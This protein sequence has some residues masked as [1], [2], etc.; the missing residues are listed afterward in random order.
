M[1][2]VS[3]AVERPR[4]TQEERSAETR[5]KLVA[6]MLDCLQEV[7]AARTSTNMVAERA[8]VSRGAL[9]HH[10]ASK[11]ELLVDAVEHLLKEASRDIRGLAEDVRAA[12]L[13]L[14]GFL[15]RVCEMYLGRLLQITLEHV[16]EARHNEHLRARLVVVVREFHAELDNIWR[17][18][19]SRTE[20]SSADA[21]T[22]LNMT[23]CMFRGMGVQT[24]LRDD[25]DYYQRLLNAWKTHVRLMVAAN[26]APAQILELFTSHKQR[27][28]G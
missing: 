19:F 2:M 26:S 12:R 5:A 27:E 1:T 24:V 8:G 9:T 28:Q 14:D 18:F 4:R 21:E 15:D 22:I 23:L 25:P 7:G 3:Q 10:Y 17:E 16:T 13:D 6:A 11:E 20:L